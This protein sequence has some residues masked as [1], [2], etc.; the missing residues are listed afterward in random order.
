MNKNTLKKVPLKLNLEQ[1]IKQERSE[2]CEHVGTACGDPIVSLSAPY[3]VLN[4]LVKNPLL[5]KQIS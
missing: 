2:K 4:S 3:N 5:T 1:S